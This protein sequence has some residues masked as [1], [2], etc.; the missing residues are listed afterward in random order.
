MKRE[1]LN[2]T[3]SQLN[4]DALM[5]F[6][7]DMIANREEGLDQFNKMFGTNIKVKKSS[8]WEDNQQENDLSHG[9]EADPEPEEKDQ[10]DSEDPEDKKEKE[11]QTE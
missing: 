3:E 7:D 6:I 11:D 10:K 5:P 1:S 8:S 9:G 2:S 4:D